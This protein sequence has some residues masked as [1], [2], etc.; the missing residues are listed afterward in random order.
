MTG[1]RLEAG[2]CML[3]ARSGAR[4]ASALGRLGLA[5]LLVSL[6]LLG[7]SGPQR[8]GRARAL[9]EV[10]M[11]LQQNYRWKY[12]DEV[13]RLLEPALLPEFE[14]RFVEPG[15][16]LVMVDTEIER[17]EMLQ[18]DASEATLVLE[19]RW[20]RL[21]SV[22]VTTSKLT[23]ILRFHNNR[24]WL[25]SQREASQEDGGPLALLEP[26][27]GDPARDGGVS[28]EGES[29]RAGRDQ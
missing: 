3:P 10:A 20:H 9:S 23:C 12:F 17:V 8:A 19:L 2:G 4:G 11:D 29:G 22:T 16:D 27:K 7:C 28:R 25:A 15:E 13:R 14:R 1:T 5:S 21:P 26:E 6:L 24:W 18:E